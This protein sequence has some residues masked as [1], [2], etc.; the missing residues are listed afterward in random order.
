MRK[1]YEVVEEEQESAVAPHSEEQLISEQ[2]DVTKDSSLEA[3]NSEEKVSEER[4]N[5]ATDKT[6]TE[7]GASENQDAPQET[8]APNNLTAE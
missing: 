6:K 4:A 7:L 1:S 3:Q 5:Q 8:P 2:K